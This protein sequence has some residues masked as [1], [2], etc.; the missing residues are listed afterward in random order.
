MMNRTL[1]ATTLSVVALTATWASGESQQRGNVAFIFGTG[2]RSCAYWRSRPEFERDGE[3]WIAGYWGGLNRAASS[4]NITGGL[5][6]GEGIIGE[7]KKICA[8]EPSTR[9][10]SAVVR[11][12]N[13]FVAS[14]K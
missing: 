8:A 1:A 13:A 3:E 2:A 10:E 7:V 6:D 12:Y 5:S 4:R 11:V 9:L 14:G